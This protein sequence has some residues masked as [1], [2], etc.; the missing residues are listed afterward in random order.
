MNSELYG[1]DYPIP[2]QI[3]EKI[4]MKLYTASDAEGI[5]R[6]KNLL[7]SGTCTY[8]NLKRLKNFFDNFNPSTESIEQ[9]ELAGG[10][11]MR[12]FVDV[13]LKK[14]RNRVEHGQ[15][16]RQDID[17]NLQADKAQDGTVNLREAVED[18]DV[19]YRNA[20]A[21]IFNQDNE[22]LIAKRNPEMEQWMP[23]KWALLGGSIEAEETAEE[24]VRREIMEEADIQIDKFL[25][26]AVVE[27]DGA[28]DHIF[29]ALY[30]H[31][32][33]GDIT[34]NNEH[35]DYM[36]CSFKNLDNYDCVPNLKEYIKLAV[37]KSS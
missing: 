26:K 36:F 17:V 25:K 20:I 14:E 12:N 18:D 8:Q 28:R 1:N 24:A 3:L 32:K 16:V 13:T 29:L 31:D 6:A 10:R 15:N 7:K 27:R 34:L 22:I 5:K 9:F 35:T 21:V 23:N 11:E 19:K 33:H 30:N 37:E 4:R 2:Q